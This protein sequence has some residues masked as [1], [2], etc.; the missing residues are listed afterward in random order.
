[1]FK[2]VDAEC[3][4][5]PKYCIRRYSSEW[6]RRMW[7]AGISYRHVSHW[8]VR[9]A[10]GCSSRSS[11]S[12]SS[13]RRCS[14]MAPL[15][16]LSANVLPFPTVSTNGCPPS[17]FAVLK[18]LSSNLNL[19][20]ILKHLMLLNQFARVVGCGVSR[21]EAVPPAVGRKWCRTP[22]LLPSHL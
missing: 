17:R 19:E 10:S 3:L 8:S 4:P 13:I 21:P 11:S 6:S 9:A 5:N 14:P 2:F 12:C 22:R 20:G 7:R 1:M 15:L 18:I 16:P